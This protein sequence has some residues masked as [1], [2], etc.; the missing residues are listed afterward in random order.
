MAE[1]H[2]TAIVEAG[3]KLGRGVV[4]GPWCLIGAETELDDGVRV[5]SH[6]VVTGR[7]RLGADCI[8]Y[9]FASIGHP[10]QDMKYGGEASRL[11]VGC[12]NTIREHVTI[13]PGTAGG[14]MVTV[15]GDDCLFM[16]GSHVAHDCS[17]GD[18][19]ILANNATLAGHV[20]VQDHAV[21]GGL[22]GVHQFVRVGAYA[23][24]GGMAGVEHDVPPY[25]VVVGN[26]ARVEGINHVGLRRH[27]F[28]RA[29]I[30]SIWDAFRILFEGAGGLADRAKEIAE[31][32]PESEAVRR[33]TSFIG[34][35]AAR[36]LC[37]PARTDVR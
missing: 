14:G 23:M 13:N 6:A 21:L 10:P 16:A 25:A 35:D 30:E 31:R 34:A 3:A 5:I 28:D 1:V 27:G 17:I 12:R 37:R 4:I 7:T 20:L 24:V 2:P 18:R 15:I 29:E 9:P 26:R 32:H 11:V 36:P 8:V 33:L 19:V 22:C